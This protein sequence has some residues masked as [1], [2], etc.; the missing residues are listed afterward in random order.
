MAAKCRWH[1]TSYHRR[2]VLFIDV[3]KLWPQGHIP[4]AYFLEL[5][6]EEF[7]EVR[8]SEIASKSQELV[9]YSSSAGGEGRQAADACAKAATWGFAK[10]YYFRD[11]FAGWQ[12]AGYRGQIPSG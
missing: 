11:G 5:W 7:N 1:N 12:G 2:G 3:Y 4:G 6:T 8:L 10:V 9:I